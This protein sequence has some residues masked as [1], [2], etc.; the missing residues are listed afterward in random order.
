MVCTTFSLTTLEINTDMGD[1]VLDKVKGPPCFAVMLFGDN[2]VL[3]SCLDMT[4][5]EGNITVSKTET[6][7]TVNIIKSDI[8]NGY[9]LEISGI[10]G[11]ANGARVTLT[12]D[13]H[14]NKNEMYMG[15]L[16]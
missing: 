9:L 14:M 16:H 2:Y 12:E 13:F 6:F 10:G 11:V 5:N 7:D 1:K 15:T 3:R 8:A 4:V